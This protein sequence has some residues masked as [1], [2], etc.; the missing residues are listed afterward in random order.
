MAL[1][2]C[3]NM[4]EIPVFVLTTLQFKPSLAKYLKWTYSYLFWTVSTIANVQGK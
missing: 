3:S 2:N 4:K 1:L